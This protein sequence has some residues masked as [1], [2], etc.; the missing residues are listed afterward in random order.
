MFK[1]RKP[2]VWIGLLIGIAS[3]HLALSG[4]LEMHLKS[5][6][7]AQANFRSRPATNIIFNRGQVTR[8]NTVCSGRTV[9][10]INHEGHN[11]KVTSCYKLP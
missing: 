11:V 7:L 4:L 8:K 1:L 5:R 2:F 9:L 3:L 6:G 10:I